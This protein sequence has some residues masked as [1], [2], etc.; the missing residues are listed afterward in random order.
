MGTAWDGAVAG[1]IPQTGSVSSQAPNLRPSRFKLSDQALQ[2]FWAGR[3]LS[4][5]T[6]H[7]VAALVILVQDK[8]NA[9]RRREE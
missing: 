6:A 5:G 7:P 4:G 8:S 1:Q 2:L 3:A 9:T